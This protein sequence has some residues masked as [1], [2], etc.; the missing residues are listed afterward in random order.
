MDFNLA[1]LSVRRDIAMLGVIHRAILRQGPPQLWKFFRLDLSTPVR[2]S[3]HAKR[4]SRH[5]VEW[6]AGRS[7][8]IMRRSALGMI[9]IYNLLPDELVMKLSVKEFQH[10]LTVLVK[11]V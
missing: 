6:P 1:P 5:V 7:L 8:D 9:R 10:G 11:T 4:H 2:Q 3:R